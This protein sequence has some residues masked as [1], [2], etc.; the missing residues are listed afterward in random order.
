MALNYPHLLVFT[1]HTV[2]IYSTPGLVYV[3]NSMWQKGCYVTSNIVIKD[4]FLFGHP[5]LSDHSFWGKPAV[6]SCWHSGNISR[7]PCGEE[8]KSL[9][10][11]QQGTE[12]RQL[13]TTVSME[14]DPIAFSNRRPFRPGLTAASG[15]ALSQNL[16]AKQLLDS[17]PTETVTSEM[18]AV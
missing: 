12:A 10:K 9:V 17:R 8:L 11:S 16:L 18:F 3:T 15:G 1:S 14:A 2:P 7:G 13:L 4:G 5:L 6:M